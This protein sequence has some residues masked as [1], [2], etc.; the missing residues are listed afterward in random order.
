MS[1]SLDLRSNGSGSYT[2][3]LNTSDTW[4]TTDS[5]AILLQVTGLLNVLVAQTLFVTYVASTWG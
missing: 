4:R 2:S 3:S 1:A 5:Q